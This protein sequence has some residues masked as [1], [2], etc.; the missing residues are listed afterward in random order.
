MEGDRNPSG[1]SLMIST[2]EK[3][4]YFILN[5]CIGEFKLSDLAKYYISSRNPEGQRVEDVSRRKSLS[6]CHSG[7]ST[8]YCPDN[9]SNDKAN[10]ERFDPLVIDALKTLGINHCS[11]LSLSELNLFR[12]TYP[13]FLTERDII[14]HIIKI[15]IID[16]YEHA[17]ISTENILGCLLDNDRIKTKDNL[18]NVK[19]N[20]KKMRI[21]AITVQKTTPFGN[22]YFAKSLKTTDMD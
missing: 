17:S 18:E 20:L 12:L 2:T 11:E 4:F 8:I 13:S 3:Y 14:D 5:K 15:K 16:G 19:S 21:D 9:S 6:Q 22:E 1:S 10:K 7:F